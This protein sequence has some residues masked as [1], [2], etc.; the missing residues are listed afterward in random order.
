[1]RFSFLHLWLIMMGV[2]QDHILDLHQPGGNRRYTA[3]A[4]DFL[5]AITRILLLLVSYHKK[6]VTLASY[7]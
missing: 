2:L 3:Y 6:L 1:M 5:R 7:G 4:V